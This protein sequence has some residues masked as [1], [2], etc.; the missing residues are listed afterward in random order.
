M[1]HLYLVLA[2]A[3]SLHAASPFAGRW[4]ITVTTPSDSYPQWMEYVER[5]SGPYIRIQPRGGAVRDAIDST[6]EAGKL[7]IKV[8]KDVSWELTTSGKNFTGVQKQGG[9]ENA[10]LAGVRAPKLDRKMPKKWSKP[11]PLINGKDLTGWEPIAGRRPSH[12][13]AK[14]GELINEESGANIKTTRKFD[15]FKLHVEFICPD[16]CNSGLYL[17]GRYEIQ[18]GSEGGKEPTHEMGA[19]YGYHAPAKTMPLG[20]GEWQTYDV[21]LVG[22]TVTVVRNGVVIHE[23]Q[24]IAGI[25]GG[26]LD[27]NEGEPGP[28]FLQG[29]HQGRL[30]FRNM[31]IS[32]P[33]K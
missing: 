1:N 6:I 21:T 4:D 12:W 33:K 13:I 7:T 19:I 17:R 23:K 9:A 22:R 11:E 27:S 15:D 3:S 20:S 2:L 25:T 5:A 30:R 14:D 16:H 26:A 18:I 24:E 31:T 8:N 29:D 32:V 28:F 10:K